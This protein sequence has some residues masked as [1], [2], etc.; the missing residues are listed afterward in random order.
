[1][2]L[3][4]FPEKINNLMHFVSAESLFDNNDCTTLY[5]SAS[6]KQTKRQGLTMLA[7]HCPTLLNVVVLRIESGPE[8]IVV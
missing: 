8:G 1:M 5:S 7:F 6:S 4:T 3:E 2:A